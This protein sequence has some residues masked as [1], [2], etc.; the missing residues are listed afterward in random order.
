MAARLRVGFVGAGAAAQAIHVPTLANLTDAFEVTG[1]VDV[2]TDLVHTV[3]ERIHAEVFADVRAL[4]EAVDV[5]CICSPERFHADHVVE[6][7]EVGVAAI[8]CEKPLGVT[9]ADA[10][11]IADVVRTTRTPLVVGTMHMTDPVWLRSWERARDRIGD[12]IAVDSSVVVPFN[13]RFEDEGAQLAALSGG[14]RARL[15]EETPAA[16]VRRRFLLLGIHDIPLLRQAIGEADA[17]VEVRAVEEVDPIGFSVLAR[18]GDTA[19]R[20][21]GSMRG[22]WDPQWDLTI[23][24]TAGE[25]ALRFPPSF[26]QAGSAE[27]VLRT[28]RST[29]VFEATNVSGYVGEWELIADIVRGDRAAPDIDALVADLR[30]ALAIA[31]GAAARLTN[32]VAA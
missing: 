24:G 31:D 2:D 9:G 17:E 6:A 1:V 32:G 19:L 21:L 22:H 5:V 7:A 10:E 20:F 8:L 23:T 29:E 26:V 12:V 30:F 15:P 11:R 3:A 14:S 16:R 18:A 13:D 27:A 28:E 25:L 4:A